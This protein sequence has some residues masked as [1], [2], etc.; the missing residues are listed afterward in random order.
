MTGSGA[1]IV[2]ARSAAAFLALLM[3]FGSL[4][5]TGT[6]RAAA[7]DKTPRRMTIH[8]YEN[9]QKTP[10][11]TVA[12]PLSLATAALRV[13]AH[14]KVR[15]VVSDDDADPGCDAHAIDMEALLQAIESSGPGTLLEVRDHGQRLAISLE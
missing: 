8:V 12:V 14:G 6:A 11:V 13:A 3:T 7:D 5:C 10:T 1:A 9:D 15:V 2:S 4:A